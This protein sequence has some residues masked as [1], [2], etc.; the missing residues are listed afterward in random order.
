MK[1]IIY[2]DFWWRQITG[3]GCWVSAAAAPAFGQGPVSQVKKKPVTH[4]RG[5]TLFTEKSSRQVFSFFIIQTTILISILPVLTTAE[6]LQDAWMA[7]LISF[8]SSA[9]LVVIIVKLSV[10]FPVKSLGSTARN[11]WSIPESLF[12]FSICGFSSYGR[13]DLR[14]YAEVLKPVFPET[15]LVVIMAFMVFSLLSVY[16]GLEPIGRSADLFS[17]VSSCPG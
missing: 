14:I 11:C 1:D 15:P 3:P 4:E 12:P 8:F 6:A 13:S 2:R 9:A 10:A 17:P 16:S 5:D 7:A